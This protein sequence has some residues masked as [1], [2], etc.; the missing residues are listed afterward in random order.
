MANRAKLLAKASNSP[1]NVRF[2]ELCRLAECFGWTFKRQNGT[3]HCIY[4]NLAL[5]LDQGRRMNFQD[6]K[7][8]AKA[9]QVRQLLAAIENLPN[10]E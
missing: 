3:S 2:E 1:N 5:T 4:V 8:K 10:D 9:S 6:F 7:G